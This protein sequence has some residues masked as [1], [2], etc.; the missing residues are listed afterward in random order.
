MV[1][2][3]DLIV[4]LN[5]LMILRIILLDKLTPLQSVSHHRAAY[6]WWAESLDTILNITD[7][8]KRWRDLTSSSDSS[9]KPASVLLQKCGLWGCLLGGVLAANIAQ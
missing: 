1:A 7:S 2:E 9:I 5:L 6:K 8:L 4:P 3:T